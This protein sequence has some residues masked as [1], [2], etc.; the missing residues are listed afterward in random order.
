MLDVSS[1]RRKRPVLSLI[2]TVN[3]AVAVPVS[4]ASAATDA[5]GAPLVENL[6][7]FGAAIGRAA[8][9]IQDVLAGRAEVDP[10]SAGIAAGLAIAAFLALRLLARG[11]GRFARTK[12]QRRPA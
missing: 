1:W 7:A 4:G 5:A 12:H 2:G 9:T 11:F 3:I 10:M 8:A 6:S